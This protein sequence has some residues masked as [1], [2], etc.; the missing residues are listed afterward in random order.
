MSLPAYAYLYD[1][2]GIQIQGN[3]KTLGREGAIEI[4]SSSYGVSQ[5]VDSFTGRMTGTRQ[6]DAFTIHKQ[7]DKTSPFLADCVCQSR[8]FQK[9]VIHYFDI[10]DAGIEF[11]VYRV[12]L[13]SVVVAFVNAAHT[14]IPGSGTPNMIESVGFRFNAI[15]WF[16]LDGFIKYDDAWS[17][18][19]QPAQK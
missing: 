13:D 14:Y 8:R 11:E 9:M 3:C 15:E 6:H 17:R 5:P 12:T 4:M 10:N 1:E 16:Y 18:P 7:V 19:Q 2:N